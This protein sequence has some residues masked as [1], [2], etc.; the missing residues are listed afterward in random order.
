MART[1]F[2]ALAALTAL[3]GT[4]MTLSTSYQAAVAVESDRHPCPGDGRHPCPKPTKT[5][6][7][8]HSMVNADTDRHPCPDEGRH[9]CPK[10]TKTPKP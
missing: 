10:P 4:Q 6:P 5:P 8:A 2:V 9:P 3:I 7:P 1:L